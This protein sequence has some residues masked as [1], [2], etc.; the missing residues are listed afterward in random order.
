MLKSNED[1]HVAPQ[2]VTKFYRHF[3]GGG[4]VRTPHHTNIDFHISTINLVLKFP[5]F[6][7]A[8][9]S[10]FNGYSLTGLNQ[11]LTKGMEGPQLL[12]LWDWLFQMITFQKITENLTS[13]LIAWKAN[14]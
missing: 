3:Y 5:L 2:L 10:S 8:L 13:S 14:S 4:Q 6:K 1:I 9:S 12:V 7:G 11:N